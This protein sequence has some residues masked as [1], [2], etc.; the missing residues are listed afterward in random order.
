MAGIHVYNQAT[1]THEKEVGYFYIGKGSNLENPYI[2]KD[3]GKAR[4]MFQVDNR[5]EANERFSTYFDIMYSGNNDFKRKIDEI[6][7]LYK[8]G[9]DVYLGCWCYPKKC[10]GD[11]IKAKL[12]K[13][14]LKEKIQQKTHG[15][16]N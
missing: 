14:L 11:V 5:D 4:Y 15:V 1:E 10:H 12:E 8:N 13:R 2:P 6:Y 3:E 7:L 16:N 9:Y